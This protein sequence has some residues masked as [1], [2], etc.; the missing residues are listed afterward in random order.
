MGSDGRLS[1]RVAV[2]TGG[3]QGIGAAYALGLARE[4]ARVALADVN[5]DAA[6]AQAQ[7]LAAN[8]YEALGVWVDVADEASVESMIRAVAERF[9][10]ID[11][12]V[13]NAGIFASL[14]PK[15]SFAEIRAADWDLVMQINARGPFL[16]A[17]AALPYLKAS[18]RGRIINVSSGTVLSG[19]PGFLHYVSSKGAIVAF[20]RA[21][22]REV[23]EFNIT[24]NTVAPGL[25][26][27]DGALS[28]YSTEEL[29]APAK[30]RAIKRV[31]VP[32]DLVGAVVF[33]A[34]DEAAFMTGQ[35][36]VVDGGLAL[37]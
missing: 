35:M 17:R 20:T 32:E 30:L 29:E 36:L 4:G 8:G 22:A 28:S 11:I 33:L 13:N 21:L 18:G 27:S 14:M 9:G 37:H 25:T 19:T 7:R 5:A 10:G 1:G 24:V 12:L 15:R 34:S 2:V 31:Q 3:G 26:A 23:G 6:N 16:C